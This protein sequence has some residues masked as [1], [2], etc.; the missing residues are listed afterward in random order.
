[1]VMG[2]DYPEQLFLKASHAF[3]DSISVPAFPPSLLQRE[4]PK[5]AAFPAKTDNAA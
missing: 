5:Q 1:M 3:R 4:V 2:S